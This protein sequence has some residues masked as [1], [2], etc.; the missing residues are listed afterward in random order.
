MK[1]LV[2][3]SLVTTLFFVGCNKSTP[4]S[5]NAQTNTDYQPTTVNS[6]WR[7]KDSASNVITTVTC[8]GDTKIINGVQY[9]VFT[10]IYQ[11]VVHT[12][13]ISKQSGF[14]DIIGLAGV[15][16]TTN[17][18]LL[19]YLSDQLPVGGTWTTNGGSFSENGKTVPITIKGQ[20]MEKDI[21]KM[22]G[23]T[24]FSNVIHSK[25]NMYYDY[26]GIYPNVGLENVS[27]FNFYASKGVG[28]IR[29]E[30]TLSTGAYDFVSTLT[31][32]SIQ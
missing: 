2:S 23:D 21:S 30:I 25:V 31:E 26:T 17:N 5:S 28:L 6:Y 27:T 15:N 7:S 13:Y 20:I 8:T 12:K 11:G 1:K 29:T 19:R 14:Y 16:N 24:M 10:S 9:Y 18:V 32:Y 22:I 4:S 3:I